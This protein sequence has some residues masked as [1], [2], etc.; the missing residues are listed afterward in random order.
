METLELGLDWDALVELDRAVGDETLEVVMNVDVPKLEIE[1]AALDGDEL[2][3]ILPERELVDGEPLAD[4]ELKEELLWLTPLIEELADGKP[5]AGAELE[6]ELVWLTP[7]IEE[8]LAGGKLDEELL[9]PTLLEVLLLDGTKLEVLEDITARLEDCSAEEVE[10]EVDAR[11]GDVCALE[12]DDI[13][14]ELVNSDGVG[15]EEG[16]TVPNL[17]CEPMLQL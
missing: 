10:L 16:D 1:E 3:D 2:A 13:A 7:L 12:D 6:E 4:A 11:V 5:L 17:V 8:L 9:D 15:K 14:P